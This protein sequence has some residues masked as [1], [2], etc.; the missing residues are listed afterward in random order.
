MVVQSSVVAGSVAVVL[1]ATG[2][3][4]HR[5]AELLALEGAHVRVGS[6]SVERAAE[7]C[8]VIAGRVDGELSPV[9]TADS[10]GVA[11][12]L[13]GAG[14]IEE[15]RQAY[16]ALKTLGL[17]SEDPDLEA[18]ALVDQRVDNRPKKGRVGVDET[19]IAKPQPEVASPLDLHHPDADEDH[20]DTDQADIANRF[21]DYVDGPRIEWA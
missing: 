10:D 3:V 8:E 9:A 4:G 13:V 21:L 1:G 11:A 7:T 6:R 16:D 5:A 12:A 19:G 18:L 20:G 2:P 17:E 14:E 15:A